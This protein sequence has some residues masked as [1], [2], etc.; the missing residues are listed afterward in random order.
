MKKKIWIAVWLALPLLLALLHFGPGRDWTAR[1]K[2]AAQVRKARAAEKAEQWD[3]AVRYYKKALPL[4]PEK[5]SHLRED[6]RLALA[7]AM[8]HHGEL[9][10]AI[11]AMDLLLREMQKAD[12]PSRR[13]AAV[14]TELARAQYFAAWLMRLEGAPPEEWILEADQA[15]QNF[16]FLA[17]AAQKENSAAALTYQKDL[18]ATIRLARM[19][20]S[21]LQ[22]L[23][24]PKECAACKNCSQRTREQRQS[25]A[26]NPGNEMPED[27]RQQGIGKR[28][29]G[30]GS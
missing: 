5:P 15:R 29:E 6:L 16:R 17:E 10:E 14:R 11:T 19:D 8:I 21:E 28:P 3:A 2:A 1:E 23:P 13:I 24:L 12:R 20:L 30:S 25:R 7:R 26:K 18:E 4:L 9:P 22:G 27:I